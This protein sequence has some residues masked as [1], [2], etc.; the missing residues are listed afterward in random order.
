MPNAL[1]VRALRVLVMIAVPAGI[2]AIC[3]GQGTQDRSETERPITLFTAALEG[4]VGQVKALL[5]SHRANRADDHGTTPLAMAAFGGKSQVVA[6][7]LARDARAARAVDDRGRTPLH[8]AAIGGHTEVIEQLLREGLDL[9]ATDRD[10]DAPL[11]LAARFGKPE[12]FAV[13]LAYG[14]DLAAT[15]TEGLTPV[16]LARDAEDPDLREVGGAAE[17]ES[18][19]E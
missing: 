6:L 14:G 4:D 15:D 9:N 3:W 11:H 13:L 5:D 19:I 2:V 12:A 8:W 16:D 10:G 7:L 17:V 1:L 18:Q